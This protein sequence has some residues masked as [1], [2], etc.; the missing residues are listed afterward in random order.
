MRL[1]DLYRR[2]ESIRWLAVSAAL[3]C[4]A[5]ATSAGDS[6]RANG[7]S[8]L[9]LPL[10]LIIF[11][12][13]KLQFILIYDGRRSARTCSQWKFRSFRLACCRFRFRFRFHSHTGS[14]F[15]ESICIEIGVK[16]GHWAAVD[17][18]FRYW[19]AAAPRLTTAIP[20]FV[21]PER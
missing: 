1:G 2:R 18:S 16:S 15:A 7:L 14:E 3:V 9:L 19:C 5:E 12:I 17:W 6:A 20:L 10:H 4:L 8:S 13:D 11:G 21:E